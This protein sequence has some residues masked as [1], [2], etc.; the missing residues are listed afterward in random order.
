[1]K[2]LAEKKLFKEALNPKNRK[3]KFSNKVLIIATEYFPAVNSSILAIKG[4]TDNIDIVKFDMLTTRIKS[5]LPRFDRVGKINVHRIGIGI[6][7]ID[8]Y[9]LAF[10]GSWFARSLNSQRQY[11]AIWSVG[12]DYS[13][14]AAMSFK[15]QNPEMPFLLTLQNS[16][17]PKSIRRKVGLIDPWMKKIFFLADHIQCVNSDLFEWARKMGSVNPI[18]IIPNGINFEEF[19]KGPL[20]QFHIEDLKNKLGIEE[21]DK[22]IIAGPCENKKIAKNLI[23]AVRLL[24]VIDKMPIKLIIYNSKNCKRLKK[25]IRKS[26]I[27][28]QV[29]NIKEIE[30]ESMPHYLWIS[31]VFIDIAIVPSRT[32]FLE[33][34]AAKVPIVSSQNKEMPNFFKDKET[35]LLCD[36]DEHIS[37]ADKIKTL[38]EEDPGIRGTIIANG[39]KLSRDNYSYER[40]K[41]AIEKIYDQL[42]GTK[43]SS[44]K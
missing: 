42:F 20:R 32:T 25:L 31:D 10:F 1:M 35:G 6:P 39:E 4:I 8:K 11:S 15:S 18:S 30:R 33:V 44:N 23:K 27:E 21:K 13:G 12:S 9:I 28:N 24:S 22:V 37:I 34:M 14:F 41:I 7:F 19:H 43:K 38:L 5:D 26:K 29:I 16:D 36:G 40:I 17:D 2:N 3:I